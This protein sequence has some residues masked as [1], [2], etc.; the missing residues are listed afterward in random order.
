MANPRRKTL[1][2]VFGNLG[3]TNSQSTTPR[4]TTPTSQRKPRNQLPSSIRGSLKSNTGW[5]FRGSVRQHSNSVLQRRNFTMKMD[6]NYLIYEK[7]QD[8]SSAF[9]NAQAIMHEIHYLIWPENEKAIQ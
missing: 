9:R 6:S 8:N 2:E 5:P 1:E 3:K 4:S 7:H